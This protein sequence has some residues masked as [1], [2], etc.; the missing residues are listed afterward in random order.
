MAEGFLQQIDREK[1]LESVGDDCFNELLSRSLI[2]KDQDIVEE[3]FRMH[4]LIYDLARLVSGRISRYFEGSEIPKT[5]RLLSFLREKLMSQ[6][7]LR[8]CMS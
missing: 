2:Q 4:D 3:N 8:D 5:M 1:A 7:N 6:K